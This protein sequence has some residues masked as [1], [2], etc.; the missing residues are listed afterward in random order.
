[1]FD[2]RMQCY[3]CVTN[4][5]DLLFRPEGLSPAR[6]YLLPIDSTVRC[7]VFHATRATASE[8]DP[9]DRLSWDR[10]KAQVEWR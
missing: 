6:L 2:A 8:F 7:M 10:L 5:C 3:V 4:L 1:M 9:G